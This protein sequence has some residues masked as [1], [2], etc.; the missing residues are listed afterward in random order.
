MERAHADG[1]IILCGGAINSPQLLLLSGIGPATQLKKHNI[2]I[3]M[4]LPGVGENLHDHLDVCTLYNSKKAISYDLNAFQELVIA[5]QYFFTRRGV[6]TTNAAEAGG[7]VRS[8][9]AEDGRA[10]IQFHFVP[11]LLD[12]HGRNKLPGHGY[13]IHACFLHP[14]SRGRLALQSSDPTAKPLIHANYLATDLDM[15]VMLE[16][17]KLSREIMNASAFDEYRAKEVFPGENLQTDDELR[18]FI[19]NKAETVYH[20]VGSCKMGNDEMAVV[21]PE[22]K[23][24]GVAGLRIADASIMPNI[25]SGNTNAP[26][27]MIAEK[28]ADMITGMS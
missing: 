5:L 13:T 1:E 4:E 8:R 11:A 27:I 17:A 28:A 2:D 12:D 26:T 9:F 15:D 19:R 10:D 25:T 24:R 16:A 7:F 22:L 18:A 21:D 14:Q 20:P 6:G 23:V 3:A